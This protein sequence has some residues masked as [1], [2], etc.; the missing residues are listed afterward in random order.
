MNNN[1]TAILTAAAFA[2]NNNN[3][4]NNNN[5][6]RVDLAI[7]MDT[8]AAAHSNA[9]LVAHNLDAVSSRACSVDTR[10]LQKIQTLY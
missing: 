5:D 10:Q 3:N 8:A 7:E 1:N 9:V 4:N 6:A 2:S